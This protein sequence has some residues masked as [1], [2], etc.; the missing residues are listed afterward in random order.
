MI[1]NL[2]MDKC[3]LMASHSLVSSRTILL[4]A[5]V[6]SNGE[7]DASIK[8][9]SKAIKNMGMEFIRSQMDQNMRELGLKE[10]GTGSE[11]KHLQKMLSLRTQ[12]IQSGSKTTSFNRMMVTW[13]SI[14]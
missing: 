2:D 4:M 1:S 5:W 9:N 11:S 14:L 13:T 3:L 7:M 10:K 12:T 6:S 8:V